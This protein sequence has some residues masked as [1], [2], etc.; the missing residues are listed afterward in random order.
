MEIIE[1]FKSK[2]EMI[3][4]NNLRVQKIIS[5]DMV[6]RSAHKNFSIQNRKI[7]IPFY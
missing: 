5:V 3:S 7:R 4:K 1:I 6:N 2:C